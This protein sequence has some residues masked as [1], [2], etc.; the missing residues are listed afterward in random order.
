MD[1][2]FNVNNSYA[3]PLCV[4][5]VSILEHNPDRAIRFH[6]L[7]SDFSDES[8]QAVEKI[9]TRYRNFTIDYVTPDISLFTDLILNAKHIS[10]DAY[11]RYV[12]AD[13]YPAID[14]GLYLDAD[15]A[16]TGCLDELWNTDIS[17][18]YAAGVSDA[19]VEYYGH[20]KTIGL[21]DEDPYINSGV[22]LLN[23]AAIRRDGMVQKLF[24]NTR[25]I[26]DKIRY[27]DQDGANITF[28]GK[29]LP[30]HEK[31]NLCVGSYYDKDNDKKLR[32]V[33]IMHYNGCHK[34]WNEDDSLTKPHS[35]IWWK[36]NE[37][38]EDICKSLDTNNPIVEQLNLKKMATNKIA[39][40]TM[41]VG[42]DPTYFQS[43]RRYLPYN[44]ENF[45]QG[46]EVDYFLFT[47]RDETIDGMCTI[48]C[49]ATVWLYTTLLKNNM[50]AD[51]LS[52][53][54]WWDNYTHVFFIDADFAIGDRYDFF[55]HDFVCVKPYW[56]SKVCGGFYGGKTEYFKALCSLFADETQFIFE[57]K[58]PVPY[59]IDEFYLGLFSE[60]YQDHIHFIE[61][62]KQTNVLIFL[63][64]EDLEEKIRQTGK[65][66]FI[67]PY[68]AGGRA[69]K[70]FVT[71]AE[72]KEQE[73]TVNL[74]EGYIFNNFSYDFGR[75]LKIDD[76]RYRIL[77]YKR[78]EAREVLNIETF[79]ISEQPADKEPPK[80]S[81][82]KKTSA[83]KDI[84]ITP[85]ISV[86]MPVY[87]AEAFLEEAMDSILNQTF[88]DFELLVLDDGS[89]D[90]SAEI[91]QSYN[92]PRIR[93]ILC[94]HNF[95][96]TLNRGIEEARGKY[97]ARM[98]SDDIMLPHRLQVQYDYMEQH[99]D[100]AVCGSSVQWFGTQ[101][102]DVFCTNNHDELVNLMI[103]HNPIPHPST[104][105][106]RS[107]LM[108]H[109]IRYR[110]EFVLAEDYKMWTDM[111]KAGQRLHNLPE[112]LLRYRI[113]PSQVSYR[114][115]HQQLS[116]ANNIKYD[117]VYYLLSCVA[118]DTKIKE[119][120][121]DFLAKF[122]R[123]DDKLSFSADFYYNFMYEVIKSLRKKGY[124]TIKTVEQ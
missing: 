18:Y 74:E 94:S 97:I 28:R 76:T 56:G 15:M 75:L 38:Y 101:Q 59:N 55:S 31:W 108:E 32:P 63:D 54:N 9:R 115:Y 98:D 62:D 45:G 39:L 88:T 35:G 124:I 24:E 51:Y 66:L 7:T 68:K 69:N 114:K 11:F 80:T 82:V 84:Q 78:P 121:N 14:K 111:V 83:K 23:L 109:N 41:A 99:P 12:I 120:I 20:K 67:H 103:K 100:I 6:V 52:Q 36:Y 43:A 13:L 29:I 50:I 16:V 44:K 90:R 64:N 5:M 91:I 89:T 72:N 116:V 117:M 112:I 70:T 118:D 119:E 49:Q 27:Q 57:Q 105:I 65:R 86:V 104:I 77:W 123:L 47:D 93:Y 79:T 61:M 81:A 92:D 85:L 73:C 87:N 2:F 22:M 48:P 8:K 25:A 107:V 33:V 1:I 96:D 60:Q 95:V 17:N 102:Q 37:L 46:E 34:P 30:L 21:T 122:E 42:Q 26:H 58:M 19:F 71:D 53:E 10:I 3:H 113:S 4:I 110:H 106:R 40:F